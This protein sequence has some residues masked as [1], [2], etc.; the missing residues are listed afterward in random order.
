MK[1]QYTLLSILI[2]LATSGCQN[3]LAK[4]TNDNTSQQAAIQ[5]IIQPKPIEPPKIQ[6]AILLDTS[7]SMDGLIDQTRNQ[8][9]QVVNEFSKAKRHGITPRLEVALFEYGN[10]SNSADTGYV[11]MLNNFTTEL[12]AVSEGLFS[13]TTNGGSE[14]CGFV[15]KTALKNLNWSESEQDI[16]SIFIAGNEAFTQGPVNYQEAIALAK[17][18]DIRVNT[19]HAGDHLVGIQTGWQQAAVYTGGDYMSINADHKIEHI[20][21]PQDPII[22]QLNL[23]LNLTYVPYGKKGQEK[24]LRQRKQDQESQKI[25]AALLSKRAQSKSSSFYR[26]K[27]WDLVDAIE[28]GLVEEG[29]L[30]TM[31]VESLSEP[32]QALPAEK[33][34]EYVQQKAQSRKKIKLQI[35]QLV[36]Q[37]QSYILEQ[38]EKTHKQK[39]EQADMAQALVKA[40]K[41]Q[42][43]QKDYQFQK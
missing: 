8:I 35:N 22:A 29:V 37:R 3:S 42:A 39:N 14:Y 17:K 26:N 15:I 36:K 31:P 18:R 27:S 21:A 12:D 25:S 43:L 1:V 7:N 34:L 19:I 33:R 2:L 24:A 32:M 38:K 13:L 41:K 20:K 10:D 5:N 23:Q 30:E 28:E 6:L 40:I 11:K 4:N 16:R 9:W